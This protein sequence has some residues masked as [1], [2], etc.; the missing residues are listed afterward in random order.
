MIFPAGTL[1]LTK[2]RK[3]RLI[4]LVTPF[5]FLQPPGGKPMNKKVKDIQ[6]DLAQ[7]LYRSIYLKFA[8]PKVELFGGILI[9]GGIQIIT[10]IS[11]LVSDSKLL[12]LLTGIL[13]QN[14]VPSCHLKLLTS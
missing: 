3:N 12:T 1:T 4:D 14:L 2:V 8:P 11:F 9:F 10:K 5:S 6:G 13:L 7:L